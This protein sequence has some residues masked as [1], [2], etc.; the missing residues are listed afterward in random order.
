MDMRKRISWI[1]LC[2]GFLFAS[3]KLASASYI[4]GEVIVK[5]KPGIFRM[6]SDMNF[7]YQ[8]AGVASVDFFDGMMSDFEHLYLEEDVPVYE[9][10]ARLQSHPFVEYAQPN[11]ILSLPTPVLN[12]NSVPCIIPGLPFPPG[13]EDS[14]GGQPPPG[15]GIPCIIPGLPFP[16]GCSDGGGTPPEKP[17]VKPHPGD[18]PKAP[19]PM[20]GELWGMKKIE[21]EAAWEISAEQEAAEIVVAVIDTGIY[22]NHEDLLANM[23]RNPNPTKN[24]LVGYDFF[25]NDGLPYDDH[26]H[27]SHVAGTIGA[28]AENGVGVIGVAPN[29]KMM[30]IKF[31][32]KSGQGSTAGAISSIDYAVQNGA[33]ILSNSWGGRGMSNKALED[34]VTRSEQKGTLFVAAA[35]NDGNEN[36]GSNRVYPA[37]FTHSNMV[38]VAASDENDALARFSN[39]SASLVHIAAP[40]TN[41][42]ST[43]IKNEYKKYSGT[44]MACP[45]V[46]GA[47]A[48][49]W[50]MNP[51]WDYKKVRE[52]L[53]ST[54]D[55]IGSHSGKTSTGGRLNLRKAVEKANELL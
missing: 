52:I 16:P 43:V 48:L 12:T 30:G 19:D 5:Y 39:Y 9:A 49:I 21:A 25:H 13:C 35:G 15:G 42:L 3:V 41:I 26:G 29:V 51:S 11:Y 31:L 7:L 8:D 14:G 50:S 20:F 34:A 10:I 17:D 40:G 38:T 33:H 23:W 1:I 24:D 54:V 6:A 18:M 37:S 45:H 27:G 46:S 55:K 47:A 22:Y 44:S 32:S 4:P 2:F 36:A 53:F 28:V